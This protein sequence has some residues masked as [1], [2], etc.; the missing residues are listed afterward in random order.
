MSYTVPRIYEKVYQQY[1]LCD[2]QVALL[3]YFPC[4]INPYRSKFQFLFSCTEWR[5]KNRHA[6]S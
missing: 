3:V 4:L 6:V 2:M 5:T 1:S